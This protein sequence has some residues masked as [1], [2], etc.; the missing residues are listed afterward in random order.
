VP[1]SSDGYFLTP[2]QFTLGIRDGHELGNHPAVVIV[3][4][5]D[6]CLHVVSIC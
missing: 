2:R 6:G 1:R 4:S 5:S 3:M